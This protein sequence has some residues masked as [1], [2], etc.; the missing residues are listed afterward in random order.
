M[1]VAAVRIYP[2]KSLPP[3]E[4]ESA[5]LLAA[6][7]LQFD[8]RWAFIDPDGRF[9]NSKRTARMHLLRC[10]FDPQT[11]TLTISTT[12]T[13]STNGPS[14]VTWRPGEPSQ[15]LEQ[16]V[17][18]V[19][20]G[21]VQ[22]QNDA[23]GGFPDDPDSHGPTVISTASL[24]AIASWF[25]GLSLEQIRQRLRANIEISGVE[26]FWEDRFVATDDTPRPFRLGEVLLGGTDPCQRC[27]VPTRDP[28]TGDVW[29]GFQKE[30]ANRRETS[31]PE[32][33]P[34]SRFNHFYRATLNT[35]LLDGA[36]K[37]I[38]VGDPVSEM[39]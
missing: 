3:I 20:E 13:D 5:T 29:S 14:S 30:F 8:R 19:V 25:P 36:G 38:R 1:H 39:N 18:R 9:W 10:E 7:S 35:V 33:A 15:A 2:V 37:T 11:E 16:F 24:E 34:R 23:V 26:P 21:P 27:V 6:G 4:V 28:F 32:W 12:A 17:S 31:L 22:L